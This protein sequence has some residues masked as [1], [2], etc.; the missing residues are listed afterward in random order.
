MKINL[1]KVNSMRYISFVVLLS[2][3]FFACTNDSADEPNATECSLTDVSFRTDVMPIIERSCSYRS[4]CHGSGASNG[5]F[6]SYETLQEDLDN[7]KFANRALEKKDMPPQ[8]APEDRPRSLED[9]EL[10][11]IQCWADGGFQNN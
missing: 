10:N 11:I 5:D 1:S 9:A 8:Y 2:T 3:V 6:T 7:G 4:S